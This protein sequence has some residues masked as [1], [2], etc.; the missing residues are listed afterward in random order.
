MRP[1]VAPVYFFVVDVSANAVNCGMLAAAV[2]TIKGCLDR[3]ADIVSLHMP[4]ECIQLCPE[5][6]YNCCTFC[7]LQYVCFR[8]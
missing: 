8:Y 3:Y 1:P 4:T 6:A 2:E 7:M 5:F